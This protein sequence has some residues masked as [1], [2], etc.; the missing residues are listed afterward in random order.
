VQPFAVPA[1][2]LHPFPNQQFELFGRQIR[3][4]GVSATVAVATG[5]DDVG[6]PRTTAI[7]VRDQVLARALQSGNL[8]H[9]QPMLSSELFGM[10]L[11]HGHLAVIAASALDLESLGTGLMRDF[12]RFAGMSASCG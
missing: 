7:L 9:G 2:P 12:R 8:F 6:G 5:S 10:G 1:P 11:P 3:F 4:P